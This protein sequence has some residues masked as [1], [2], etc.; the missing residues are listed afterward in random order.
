MANSSFLYRVAQKLWE[1]KQKQVSNLAFVFPNRRAGLFFR[2][3]LAEIAGQPIFAPQILTINQLFQQ[4]TNLQPAD[5]IDLLFRLYH[6]Y[7][8][9]RQINESFDDF[10]FWGKMMLSDFNEVDQHLIDAAQLFT[11]LQNLK[12]IEQHFAALNEEEVE[13]VN[14]F[15]RSMHDGNANIYRERF[16]SIW[17]TLLPIY[18]RF[19]TELQAEGI[20]YTGMLQRAVV[21]EGLKTQEA[22]SKKQEYIFIGFNAL[23]GVERRLM[24]QLRDADKADFYWDYEAD[25]LRDE[26][27]RASLFYQDNLTR[28]PSQYII[29]PTQQT[30]SQ[31]YLIRI[32]SAVG[33]AQ[34][35]ERLLYSQTIAH[36]EQTAI[37]LPD[38][39]MLQPIR[40]HLPANIEHVN[41]TMGQPLKQTAAYA[42]IVHLSELALADNG[43]YYKPILSLLHHQ[44]VELLAAEE[45]QQLQTDML[46]N[47]WVYLTPESLLPYPTLQTIFSVP[48]TP[49]ETLQQLRK[50]II[51][52][53]EKQ[54][55]DIEREYLYQTLLILNRLEDILQIHATVK[56]E[57][58]TLYSLLNQ[59]L[60]GQSV[61]FEGEPLQGLQIMGVLESR[62]LDFDT[63]IVTDVNEDKLPGA[64]S[65][66]TYIPYDLRLRFGLPTSERQDAIFAYN[67]YRLLSHAKEVYLLQNTRTSELDS[68]EVSRF[69]YQLQY[70]YVIEPIALNYTPCVGSDKSTKPQEPL[71]I[72]R[73]KLLHKLTNPKRGLSASAINTYVGCPRRFYLENVEG[74]RETD[75]IE[76]NL[77]NNRLGNVVHHTM[78]FLYGKPEKPYQVGEKDIERMLATV[79][80][81]DLVE[82]EYTLE[83]YKDKEAPLI[84]RDR[85]AITAIRQYIRNILLHDKTLVPFWYYD[86]EAD[87]QAWVTTSAGLQVRLHGIIDRI[88]C[89]KEQMRVV[90]YKTGNEHHD[91][92]DIK[93][94]YTNTQK[95]ADYFRQTLFYGFLYAENFKKDCGATIYYARKAE[96]KLK[97]TCYDS[98]AQ[99]SDFRNALVALLDEMTDANNTFA[100]H[101][102]KKCD[103]CPFA[104]ICKLKYAFE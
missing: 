74:I 96:A 32:P 21:D 92:I 25:W 75:T 43:L 98:F 89:V 83:F 79:Q 78:E 14:A 84:G 102:S 27:N 19:R 26:H 77:Q 76:E 45:A 82:K 8:E 90:D 15:V 33:Q 47:N 99:Q 62:S 40:E 23:T 39:N 50:L 55:D 9:E 16:L 17:N 2:K 54:Q 34:E 58:K 29:E 70:Q 52:V 65:Q 80:K 31:L 30:E 24:E 71:N 93:E 59:L 61:A 51:L 64:T 95:D 63:I 6:I 68:G 7:L 91:A 1:E 5:N 10:L 66:N 22:R 57:V 11:N 42:F 35:I 36:N 3:Y 44:Y 37:I 28:F 12:E 72:N 97:H 53:A 49:I 87:S 4:F 88:D 41:I 81:T 73:E 46:A 94:V 69:V 86:S 101:S 67:F 48:T 56:M 85:L 104:E 13:S 60:Q 18:T 100:P 38:E 20:A 103:H